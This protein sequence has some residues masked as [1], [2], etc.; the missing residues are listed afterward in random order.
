MQPASPIPAQNPL[1][2]RT[3]DGG[4]GFG[5]SEFATFSTASLQAYPSS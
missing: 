5:A 3:T 4:N 1:P 2:R